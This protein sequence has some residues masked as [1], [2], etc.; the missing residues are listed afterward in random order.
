MRKIRISIERLEKA[1]IMALNTG[2]AERIM[3]LVESIKIIKTLSSHIELTTEE[4]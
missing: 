4:K 2:D 1:I 3:K